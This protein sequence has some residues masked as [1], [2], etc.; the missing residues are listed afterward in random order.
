MRMALCLLALVAAVDA[1][2]L[3]SHGPPAAPAVL[4]SATHD[5]A[6]VAMCMNATQATKKHLPSKPDNLYE[7]REE[8]T[9]CLTWCAD[10]GD[11]CFRGCMD[12][13]TYAL[14]PPPCAGFVIDKPQCYDTCEKLK[15]GFECMK[16]VQA[17]NTHECHGKFSS[18]TVDYNACPL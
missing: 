2:G 4:A 12:D 5:N 13:C 3:R 14:G 10:L 6:T 1:V 8:A 16:T 9:G 11:N 18:V 7:Y 17:G 15:P